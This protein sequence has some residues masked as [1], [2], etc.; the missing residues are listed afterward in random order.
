MGEKRNM[1]R[2]LA[3]KSEGKRGLGRP[4]WRCGNNINMD[5]REAGWGRMDWIDMTQDRDWW[6]DLVYTV[7]NFRVP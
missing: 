4:R 5:L 2:I 3:G 6:R 7:T 1:N